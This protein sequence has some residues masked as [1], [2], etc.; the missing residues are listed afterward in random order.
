MEFGIGSYG[1]GFL[2]GVLSSLSPC[3]L[4]LLPILITSASGEHRRGP[5]ALA[6]GLA[7]SFAVVGTLIAAVG[8]LWGIDQDKIRLVAAVILGIFGLVLLS[9]TLQQ[10]FAIA[11]AGVSSAGQTLLARIDTSGVRGQFVLG[12]LLGVVWSPCVGPTL[13][14]AVAL[15]ST[16][17]NL[18]GI[19]TLMTLFGVGAAL[20]LIGLGLVSRATMLRTRGVLMRAGQTGKPI[21]G[22]LMLVLALLIGLGYDKA[23]ESALVELSPEWL[24]RLTTRF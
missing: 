15:A 13:G 22:A 7:L 20:P 1:T 9:A 6:A 24:T 2:A 8:P 23:I 10:R 18:L 21:M 4:P 12:L 14:A 3:V 17:T 19:A 16:G 5:L 11:T